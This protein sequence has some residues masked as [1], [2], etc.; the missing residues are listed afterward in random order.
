MISMIFYIL[1]VECGFRKVVA[2]TEA[3]GSIDWSEWIRVGCELDK[4]ATNSPKTI[5][6]GI[7]RWNGTAPLLNVGIYLLK[8]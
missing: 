1:N 3:S 7:D 4:T 5:A 2:P 8:I 6:Y